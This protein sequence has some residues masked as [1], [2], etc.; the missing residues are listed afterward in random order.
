MPGACS[1]RRERYPG[2]GERRSAPGRGSIKS[3][4]NTHVTAKELPGLNHLFQTCD[5][6]AESEYIKIEET[7]SPVA[8]K[9]VS[10]WIQEQVGI[11]KPV[12]RQQQ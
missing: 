10:D 7:M 9:T 1:Q 4:G 5:T 6:G 2:S 11:E 3:G 12:D 8:L